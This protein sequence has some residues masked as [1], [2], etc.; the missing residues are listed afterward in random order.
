MYFFQILSE[1]WELDDVQKMSD[2]AIIQKLWENMQT[3]NYNT[4]HEINPQLCCY[5]PWAFSS[6][7]ATQYITLYSFYI[8]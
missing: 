2:P 7:I 1:E 6:A 8:L 5:A 3:L 4:F